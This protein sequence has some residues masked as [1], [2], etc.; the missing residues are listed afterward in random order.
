MDTEK[1]RM[2]VS[3]Y[4]ARR[5]LRQFGYSEQEI[6]E[7]VATTDWSTTT[8]SDIAAAH[9]YAPQVRQDGPVEYSRVQYSQ[10]TEEN[11]QEMMQGLRAISER[12]PRFTSIVAGTML[13]AIVG[14]VGYKVISV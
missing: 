13:L 8:P 2:K 1:N 14:Y 9:T 11:W 10:A 6:A 4:R 12:H 7:I 5:Q 3:K